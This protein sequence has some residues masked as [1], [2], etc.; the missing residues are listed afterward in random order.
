MFASDTRIHEVAESIRRTHDVFLRDQARNEALS[1][2]DDTL[3]TRSVHPG[4]IKQEPLA[5]M[6]LHPHHIPL[7]LAVDK[8]DVKQLF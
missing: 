6:A 1:R 4:T 5:S 8:F 3:S 2:S 7:L